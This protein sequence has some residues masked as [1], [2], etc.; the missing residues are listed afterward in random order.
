M[1]LSQVLFDEPGFTGKED[2]DG[3]RIMVGD[4]LEDHNGLKVQVF[5][6]QG[7]FYVA[8]VKDM[9][10]VTQYDTGTVC[11]LNLWISISYTIKVVK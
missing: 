1:N 7:K 6:K 5:E 10:F 4:T 11:S 8:E 9:N 3:N 2:Y